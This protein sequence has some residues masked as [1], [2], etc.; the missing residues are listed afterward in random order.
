MKR[1]KR[2]VAQA[3]QVAR[4]GLLGGSSP[5]NLDLTWVAREHVAY[6]DD[7]R[8][9]DGNSSLSR[10]LQLVVYEATLQ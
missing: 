10:P 5:S 2:N 6:Q 1:M 3:Y 7:N 4:L 8:T 9:A